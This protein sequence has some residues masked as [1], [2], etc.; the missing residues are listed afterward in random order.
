M[1]SDA[2]VQHLFNT[3]DVD[4]DRSINV[5]EFIVWV[6]T[7]ETEEGKEGKK[8]K[9][10]KAVGESVD[11]QQAAAKIQ[12]M[13][14]GRRIRKEQNDRKRAASKIQAIQ[15]GRK[16][17]QSLASSSAPSATS[18]TSATALAQGKRR[19]VKEVKEVE[20]VEEVEEVVVVPRVARIKTQ[21]HNGKRRNKIIKKGINSNASSVSFDEHSQRLKKEAAEWKKKQKLKKLQ[22]QELK[23]AQANAIAAATAQRAKDTAEEAAAAAKE[24][25]LQ[26]ERYQVVQ[27][28]TVVLAAVKPSG[29]TCAV[30]PGYK[31]K[32][33]QL[34]VTAVEP[35]SQSESAGIQVGWV[36]ASL[37]GGEEAVRTWNT[38]KKAWQ[39]LKTQ[40]VLVFEMSK[41][42]P[43]SDFQG[44]AADDGIDD[45]R[46]EIDV[47]IPLG[48]GID[49][50][51]GHASHYPAVITQIAPGRQAAVKGVEVG[52]HVHTVNGLSCRDKKLNWVMSIV[53]EAKKHCKITLLLQQTTVVPQKPT[54]PPSKTR[55]NDDG[56]NGGAGRVR[57]A[58]VPNLTSMRVDNTTLSATETRL[59]RSKLK[60]ASYSMNG[61]NWNKLFV[62]Y[63]VDNG[64]VL[65]YPEFKRALRSDAKMSASMLSDTQ[66]KYLFNTIDKDND[67]SINIQE[68][69]KWVESKEV[70]DNTQQ[71]EN[72][73]GSERHT[74]RSTRTSPSPLPRVATIRPTPHQPAHQLGRQLGR[75]PAQTAALQTYD[76]HTARLQQSTKEWEDKRKQQK[77]HRRVPR[78]ATLPR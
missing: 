48:M 49:H 76:Q 31:S 21:S 6:E 33:S 64:G 2:H 40:T 69:I 5:E 62:H 52:M 67:G 55:S 36:V 23:L 29:L 45:H 24:L 22:Q 43:G 73:E 58:Y 8:G 13:Q 65:E 17:R 59:I 56:D 63:D 7:V 20:E 72:I 41:E 39:V 54:P 75:Q 44:S 66:V 25:K 3:I 15:R 74:R 77:S 53:K 78:V 47:S 51:K 38:L 9:K 28:M 19:E 57:T 12:A 42:V 18:A 37:N 70:A 16:D 27:E 4:Q 71:E 32:Q 60:A 35:G 14:R 68:F 46:F 11:Q 1:L 34:V 61:V 50:P 30:V 10:G 26:T